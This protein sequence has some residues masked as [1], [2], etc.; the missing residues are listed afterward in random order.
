MDLRQN[1]FSLFMSIFDIPIAISNQSWTARRTQQFSEGAR[2]RG[3]TWK[4]PYYNVHCYQNRH[5]DMHQLEASLLLQ[6]LLLKCSTGSIA[7]SAT[8]PPVND[9]TLII[10]NHPT[11]ALQNPPLRKK[12]K[13]KEHLIFSPFFR[14]LSHGR[15]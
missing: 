9:L 1:H 4:N 2:G 8:R 3:T 7:Q 5:S 14:P 6:P 15:P 11:A 13:K 12:K 10:L